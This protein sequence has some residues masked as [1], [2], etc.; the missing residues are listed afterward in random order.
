MSS[1]VLDFSRDDEHRLADLRRRVDN[2]ACDP[3]TPE[4]QHELLH[5]EQKYVRF[6]DEGLRKLRECA[7]L[8]KGSQPSSVTDT[9]TSAL[10]GVARGALFWGSLVA[11]A[12]PGYVGK[13]IGLTEA[14][15]H[16]NWITDHL[17]LGAL[18]VV[19]QL[20]SSGNH[21]AMIGRQGEERKVTVG[22]VVSA[23]TS[24]EING[25]G[26]AFPR[27]ATHEDWQQQLGVHRFELLEI[28]DM[29]A[30]VD[31]KTV[32]RVVEKI[33][34]VISEAKEAVYVHCK[35]GKGRSWMVVMCY[36]CTYGRMTI[37]DADNLVRLKR[38]QV[39]PSASQTKFVKRF[40]P[41]ILRGRNSAKTTRRGSQRRSC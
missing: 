31:Y 26:I 10:S 23:L 13:K 39:N 41:S 22:L 4:E 14:F 21:L 5:L 30:R 33:H 11:T 15:D 25:F 28:A 19:T 40:R 12:A 24:D 38:H 3:L 1:T 36:L 8:K 7:D 6:Q 29:T 9:V 32:L 17:I 34:I 2:P 18:P 35:A 16:W 20:G 27:F 37:G